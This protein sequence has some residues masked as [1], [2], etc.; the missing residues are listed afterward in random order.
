MNIIK[1]HIGLS[2]LFIVL[3]LFIGAAIWYKIYIKSIEGGEYTVVE[4][5]EI[6]EVRQYE[7]FLVAETE[8][9]QDDMRKGGNQAF[10]ILA[11][12]I[13]G[14]NTS[15]T[16]ISMTSPVLDEVK[17]ESIAMTSPV[18]DSIDSS[19]KRVV[20]FLL[21]S[22]YTLETL[23]VPNDDRVILREVSA[24][25]IAVIRF[26][27]LWS[28]K[29]FNTKLDELRASL[30]KDKKIFGDGYIRASYDPPITPP[31]LRTNE[32]HVEIQ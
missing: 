27:G 6:Y 21:P 3:L 7:P 11:G 32:I 17:G 29:R 15:Q 25:K 8:I 9:N 19:G 23:P 24:K 1:N 10:P 28:Q 20:S 16:K 2:V 14:G 30:E 4:K 22:K 18:L 13:F 5:N 31:F 12:Y 26:S